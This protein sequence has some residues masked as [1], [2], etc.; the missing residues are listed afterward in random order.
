MNLKFKTIIFTIINII[1]IYIIIL[2]IINIII[3]IN[4]IIIILIINIIYITLRPRLLLYFSKSYFIT[5]CIYFEERKSAVNFK[6][7]V[8]I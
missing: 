8:E 6:R 1:V 7:A 4:V 2:I 3:I 5:N